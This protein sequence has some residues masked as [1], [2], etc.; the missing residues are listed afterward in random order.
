MYSKSILT[1][2]IASALLTACSGRLPW[3]HEP[4]GQE[5]NVVLALRGNL[6][7]LPSVSVDGAP[8]RFLLAVANARTAIDPSFLGRLRPGDTHTLEL[9]ARQS[10]RFTPA[11]VDLHGLADGIIGA[12]VW[13]SSAITID[14]RTGLLTL[15][16]EGIHPEL[17]TLTRFDAE[18]EVDLTIDGVTLR[19]VLDTASPD[20]VVLPLAGAAPSRRSAAIALAGTSFGSTDVRLGSVARPR[21]GN[22]LLSKFLVTVDYGRKQVGL[23]RD[24]RIR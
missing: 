5:V 1:A 16:R 20:S 2:M 3:S 12:D 15:Q 11:V 19:A 24:P 23:W 6:L 22:R 21:V 18:P 17:M 13:Q 9:N 8:G 7:L 4:I 10:L 14:Y